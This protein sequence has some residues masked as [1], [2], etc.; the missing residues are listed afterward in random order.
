MRWCHLF[1]PLRALRDFRDDERGSFVVEAIIALPLLFVALAAS[2][3]FFEV[4]RFKSVREKATYTI[5]DMLSREQDV[6]NDTYIDNTMQLLNIIA[7]DRGV[8]QLRAS[9]I[10]YDADEDRYEVVWS[11]VR[12]SGPM[13]A[14]RDADV[15]ADRDRLPVLIDGEQVILVETSSR[16]DS[17]FDLIYSE[18]MIITTRIF[19]SIRFAPQLCFEACRSA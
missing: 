1:H 17:V 4:H 13:A 7:G 14:L 10:R 11:E 8:N 9:V 3:E 15:N 16:Y 2:F 12:G 19:T 6:V 18:D 5:A